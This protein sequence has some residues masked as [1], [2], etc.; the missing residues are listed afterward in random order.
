MSFVWLTLPEEAQKLMQQTFIRKKFR[1]GDFVYKTNEKPQGMYLIQEGLIGIVVLAKNGSEHLLRLYGEG[2]YFG[3]RSLMANELYYADA[4]C[5]EE[6]TIDLIPSSTVFQIIQNF[7]EVQSLIIE[8]LV[9]DLRHAEMQRISLGEQ[10]VTQRVAHS[11]VYLKERYPNHQ[12]TRKE[13]AD[14]CGTT[15][16]T[17]IKTL[18]KFVEQQFIKYDGRRIAILDKE[19]LLTL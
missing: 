9:K 17:A 2:Q 11:L 1:R 4:I 10:D 6:C 14:F 18:A 13:I 8:H 16:A 15:T 5:L 3:H 12:W 19:A 7:P